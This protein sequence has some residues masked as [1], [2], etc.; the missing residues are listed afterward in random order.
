MGMFISM[1]VHIKAFERKLEIYSRDLKENKL[2]YF[3]LLKKYFLTSGFS[4]DSV[5]KRQTVLNINNKEHQVFT[6]RDTF[7]FYELD[8]TL[9]FIQ[10][11][12]NLQFHD[13]KLSIGLN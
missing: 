4:T 5:E 11:L 7:Q 8:T 3:P 9:Q 10:F 1:F 2:K 13:L 12:Y 6:F